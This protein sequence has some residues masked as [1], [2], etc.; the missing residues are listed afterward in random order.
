V[1]FLLDTHVLVWAAVLPSRLSARARDVLEDLENDIVVSAAC[2]YEIEFKRE[3][4]PSLVAMPRE[5][6]NA[7][8]QRGFTWLSITPA[9]AAAAGRLPRLHG[10]PFDRMLVAQ[11]ISEGLPLISI[12]EKLPAYGA[13]IIW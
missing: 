7:V 1:K 13:R 5:L 12:D 6:E 11:A 10:D 2:A 4:D 3:R 8:I 9:H